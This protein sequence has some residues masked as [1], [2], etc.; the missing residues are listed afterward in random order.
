MKSNVLQTPIAYLK[1]VLPLV[2]NRA[3]SLQWNLVY[4][5]LSGFDKSF[6]QSHIDKT[7]IL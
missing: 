5:N 4:K 3:D 2:P 7:Q 6:S 1:R